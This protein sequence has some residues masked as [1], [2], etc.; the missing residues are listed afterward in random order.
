[1]REI[2]FRGRKSN[3]EWIYGDLVTVETTDG[4]P[5]KKEILPFDKVIFDATEEVEE[6]TIGQFT[7][8]YDENDEEIYEW[9][10]VERFQPMPH[11][12]NGVFYDGNAIYGVVRYIDAGFYILCEN[13][14]YELSRNFDMWVQGNIHDNPE[15]LNK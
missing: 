15:L 10:I 13:R 1:M 11:Y 5:T 2:K 9:D 6:Y 8:L 14:A 12:R 3:G 4:I 7:G